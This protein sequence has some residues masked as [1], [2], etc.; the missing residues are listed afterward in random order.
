MK[1]LARLLV[2]YALAATLGACGRPLPRPGKPVVPRSAVAGQ[3]TV[4]QLDPPRQAASRF[5]T[6]RCSGT[7]TSQPNSCWTL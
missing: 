4:T 1:R 5:T 6:S 7:R 2:I 3:D